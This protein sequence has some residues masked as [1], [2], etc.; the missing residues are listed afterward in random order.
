MSSFF[1]DSSIQTHLDGR[2]FDHIPNKFIGRIDA[3]TNH[4]LRLFNLLLDS[5]LLSAYRQL[6][7]RLVDYRSNGLASCLV[8]RFARK[9][10]AVDLTHDQLAICQIEVYF[11]FG[12]FSYGKFASIAIDHVGRSMIDPYLRFL[13]VGVYAGI[14]FDLFGEND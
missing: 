11:L 7:L 3:T 14:F 10:K 6:H 1:G 4:Y 5:R 13:F 12:S 8:S 9:R 2:L